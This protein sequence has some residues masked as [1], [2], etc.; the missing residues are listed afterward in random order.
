MG[1]NNKNGTAKAAARSKEVFIVKH[2]D[3]DKNRVS[4]VGPFNDKEE[5]MSTC[6]YFLKKG[7]CSWFVSCNG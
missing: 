2:V 1:K 4:Q 5:A 7:T 6:Q 3:P